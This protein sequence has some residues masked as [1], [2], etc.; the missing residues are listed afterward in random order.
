M[1]QSFACLYVHLI[2]ST[3]NRECW[4]D[5]GWAPELYKYLAGALS[6]EGNQLIAAGGIT[7]HVHLLLSLSRNTALADLVREVKANSSKW[8]HRRFPDMHHFAWQRGYAA[9]SVSRSGL[10]N[11]RHYILR[12][13]EHHKRRTFREELL[14][15]LNKHQV[16]YD[17]KYVFD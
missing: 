11:V 6:G 12:Q 9:F 7:D 5:E 14:S 15:L 16:E 3:K 2:F 10:G 1:P 4:I 8:V 13:K 17:E